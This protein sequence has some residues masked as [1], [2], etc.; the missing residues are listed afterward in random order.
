MLRGEAAPESDDS[1]LGRKSTPQDAEI[2]DTAHLPR[3]QRPFL[4]VSLLIML[5]PVMPGRAVL[6]C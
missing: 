5:A 1:L 4:A 6:G 3:I 2:G